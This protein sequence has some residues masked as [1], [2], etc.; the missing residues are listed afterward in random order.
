MSKAEKKSIDDKA[1]IPELRA[2]LWC[3]SNEQYHCDMQFQGETE[4]A[5]L[6]A[7]GD[8]LLLTNGGNAIGVRRIYLARHIQGGIRF[9][10]DRI[11]D[12]TAPLPLS[13]ILVNLTTFEK[14][15]NDHR[16]PETPGKSQP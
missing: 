13:Q 3:A 16:N 5:I 2:W 10:F 1:K 9:Y 12:F 6:P 11:I 15:S 7:S 4:Q 8:A 14:D